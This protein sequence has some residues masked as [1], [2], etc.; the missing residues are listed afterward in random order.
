MFYLEF[1]VDIVFWK[2]NEFINEVFDILL[3]EII[4]VMYIEC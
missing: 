1:L 3:K 4:I 2:F